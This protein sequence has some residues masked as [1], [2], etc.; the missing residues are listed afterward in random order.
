MFAGEKSS[1]APIFR[2]QANFRRECMRMCMPTGPWSLLKCPPT[3]SPSHTSEY[4]S[5]RD[6]FQMRMWS[7]QLA[8]TS[9][10]LTPEVPK[11]GAL[12]LPKQSL[13][14]S[15][16]TPKTTGSGPCSTAGLLGLDQLLVGSV[17]SM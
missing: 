12:I 17:A 5:N 13:R 7:A 14:R 4:G 16:I 10:L 8:L 6:T 9:V 2:S 15:V 11:Y 3:L 1:V